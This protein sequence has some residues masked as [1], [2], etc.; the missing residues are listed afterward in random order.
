MAHLYSSCPF[1]QLTY[2]LSLICFPL[3]A[4]MGLDHYHPCLYFTFGWEVIFTLSFENLDM[5]L[6]FLFLSYKIGMVIKE[7]TLKV[8]IQNKWKH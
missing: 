1:P 5:T 8:E 4:E 3:P 6:F 2:V 7:K